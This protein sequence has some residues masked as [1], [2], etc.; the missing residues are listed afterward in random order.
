MQSQWDSARFGALI[1]RLLRETGRS[2]RAL[3]ALGPVDPSLL[4]RWLSG[5]TRP[6]FENLQTF[7]TGLRREYPRLDDLVPE[8]IDA[9]GYGSLGVLPQDDR[10]GVVRDHWDDAEVRALWA[11]KTIPGAA[12][13]A[14]IE[15]LLVQRAENVG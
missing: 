4:S 14:L 5:S 9:A 3:A 10:P 12:K 2:Q 11:L 7:I 15:R 8:L 6:S 13:A 1:G